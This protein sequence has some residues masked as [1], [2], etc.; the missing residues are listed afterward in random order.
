[1]RW[2]N[3]ASLPEMCSA[4]ATAQSLAE[5][6]A[7]H[8]I[9]SATLIC[10]PCSSHIWLPPMLSARAEAVTVSSSDSSPESTASAAS[11]SVMTFVTDA[12]ARSALSPLA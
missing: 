11:S 4:S 7:M 3:A 5:T 2:T 9:I 1:M 10:S 12:G 8:F 6:T